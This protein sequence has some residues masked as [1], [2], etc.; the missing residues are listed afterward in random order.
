MSYTKPPTQPTQPPVENRPPTYPD[1][2]GVWMSKTQA[3][4]HA[5][6]H[7]RHAPCGTPAMPLRGTEGA[8]VPA[9]R[10]CRRMAPM[11]TEVAVKGLCELL[12]YFLEGVSIV[13]SKAPKCTQW[14][15]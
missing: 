15:W 7:G 14:N 6:A 4:F 1:S 2:S 8:D 13:P 10:R 12:L 5:P 3:P 9:S 11:S